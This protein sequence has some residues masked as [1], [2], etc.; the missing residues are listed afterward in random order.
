MIYKIKLYY[1]FLVCTEKYTRVHTYTLNL[2]KR[3]KM[4]KIRVIIKIEK[5]FCT[6]DINDNKKILLH[7]YSY[8]II[9]SNLQLYALDQKHESTDNLFTSNTTH[10]DQGYKN[11]ENFSFIHLLL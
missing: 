2:N 8:Y 11:F 4:K 9:C 5:L 10:I 1:W 7:S 6:I 3:K